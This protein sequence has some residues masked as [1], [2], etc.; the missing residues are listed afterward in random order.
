MGRRVLGREGWHRQLQPPSPCPCA[1]RTRVAWASRACPRASGISSVCRGVASALPS[2]R[3]G[4]SAGTAPLALAASREQAGE[5]GARQG[6]CPGAAV[7]ARAEAAGPCGRS[8]RLIPRMDAPCPGRASFPAGTLGTELCSPPGFLPGGANR[9]ALH[10][11][12]HLSFS[13]GGSTW[14]SSGAS[15]RAMP[16]P[17]GCCCPVPCPAWPRCLRWERGWGL[18]ELPFPVRCAQLHPRHLFVSLPVSHYCS[19]TAPRPRPGY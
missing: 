2:P 6:G 11:R 15:P 9:A 7:L 1:C 14:G 17:Q 18:W 12:S 13:W 8:T 10:L 16:P 5:P 19:F 4:V 3:G